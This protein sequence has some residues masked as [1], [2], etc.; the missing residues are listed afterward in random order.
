MR[1]KK[2]IGAYEHNADILVW[3]ME[4][5]S[6]YTSIKLSCGEKVAKYIFARAGGYSE[7]V[8]PTQLIEDKH[9][10]LVR[11]LLTRPGGPRKKTLAKEILAENQASKGGRTNPETVAKELE[12]IEKQI[13]R[14]LKL[15]QKLCKEADTLFCWTE[16]GQK[17]VLNEKL[18]VAFFA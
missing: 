1:K 16:E 2:W 18:G 9:L 11:R 14:A 4:A 6:L 12:K 5:E 10:K 17:G 3:R 15:E 8:S 7:P 13:D